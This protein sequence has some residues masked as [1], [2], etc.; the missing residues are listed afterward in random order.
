LLKAKERVQLPKRPGEPDCTWADV[1]RIE[2]DL[3]WR[4]KVSFEEGVAKM[5]ENIEYWRHAPVWTRERIADATADWFRY[6][7]G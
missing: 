6:L 5:L 7:G 1:T 3:G 4:A 2:R